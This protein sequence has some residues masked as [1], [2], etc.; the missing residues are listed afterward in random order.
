MPIS[1]TAALIART[2]RFSRLSGLNASLRAL[3]LQFAGN[4]REQGET[5]DAELGR[6]VGGGDRQ[7]DRQPVDARHRDD[8]FAA[9]D[10]VQNEQRPDQIVDRQR[11]LGDDTTVPGV[12]AI[13]THANAG[14]GTGNGHGRTP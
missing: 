1:G 6:V 4:D 8:G 9:I 3:A 10:A 2:A 11:V 12:G 7:I 14:E 5:G 13:A